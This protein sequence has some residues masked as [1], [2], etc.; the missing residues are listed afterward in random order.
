[1][2][3]GR[4]RGRNFGML[5]PRPDAVSN[6]VTLILLLFACIWRNMLQIGW[7]SYFN[8]KLAIASS[9][10]WLQNTLWKFL[11]CSRWL[12]GKSFYVHCGIQTSD[13]SDITLLARDF[14]VHRT[15]W[16]EFLVRWSA[17]DTYG[18][19]RFIEPALMKSDKIWCYC[20]LICCHMWR[21]NIITITFI[22]ILSMLLFYFCCTV[23]TRIEGVTHTI[24]LAFAY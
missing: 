21:M 18:K 14:F 11:V 19:K 9:L 15:Y 16:P 2:T 20:W 10:H 24:S 13:E 22:T 4:Q 7:I 8:V 12:V 3:F 17:G 23:S 1:M 6:F 5:T